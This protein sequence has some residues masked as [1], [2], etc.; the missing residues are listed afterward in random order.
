MYPLIIFIAGLCIAT[1]SH[2]DQETHIGFSASV[3]VTGF[4]SPKLEEVTVEHVTALSPAERAGLVVGDRIVAIEGCPVLGCGAF[5]AKDLMDRE[6][7][8]TLHL[9]VWVEGAEPKEVAI[10]VE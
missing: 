3:S 7:G 5:K 9:L 6:A 2:A 8:E 4:F 1:D 10:L